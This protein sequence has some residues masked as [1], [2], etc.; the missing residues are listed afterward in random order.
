MSFISRL[1]KKDESSG[2]YQ[3]ADAYSGLRSMLLTTP[4]DKKAEALTDATWAV[5]MESGYEKAVVTLVA[6]ADGAVSLYFSNGG[7]FIGM[8]AQDGPQQAAA[9]LLKAAS[10]FT[11]FLKP[12]NEYPLPEPTHTRFFVIR[13]SDVLT[14]EVETNELGCNR[15]QLSP[16]FH[17]AHEVIS[18]IRLTDERLKKKTQP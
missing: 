10:A 7:G 1:F 5:L 13:K 3:I 8:G 6:V 16:L 17:L 2:S 4:P 12:T 11:Q 14:A 18:Q 9:R 15:H